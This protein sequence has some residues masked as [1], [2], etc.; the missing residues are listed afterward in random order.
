M[1]PVGIAAVAPYNPELNGRT[2]ENGEGEGILMKRDRG[3]T[4][5]DQYM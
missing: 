4:N 1:E 3:E 2:E 5:H